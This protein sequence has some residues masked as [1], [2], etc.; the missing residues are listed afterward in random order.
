M[1]R[2]N[3]RLDHVTPVDRPGA[4]VETRPVVSRRRVPDSLSRRTPDRPE[5]RWFRVPAAW[6]TGVGARHWQHRTCRALYALGTA[7]VLAPARANRLGPPDSRRPPDS[8]A[9]GLVR[10]ARHH[11]VGVSLSE[12]H[13][14]LRE[15]RFEPSAWRAYRGHRH[16]HVPECA[17]KR[18]LLHGLD[19]GVRAP[20][21]R[22][23]GR[24]LQAA[25]CADAVAHPGNPGAVRC[26][27]G[28]SDTVPTIPA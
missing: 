9:V 22:R 3:I 20:R 5:H 16:R 4:M 7:V 23:R 11:M 28:S 27:R 8:A 17:S 13:P 25:A 24:A 10:R 14:G 6:P 26:P 21:L 15:S 1:A 19:T 12:P 2:A 18:L